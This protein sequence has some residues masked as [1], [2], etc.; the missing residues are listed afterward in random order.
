LE[1]KQKDDQKMRCAD[2]IRMDLRLVTSWTSSIVRYFFLFILL[3]KRQTLDKA[4]ETNDL[5]F[6]KSKSEP[7]RILL[8]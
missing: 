1:H 6:D 5:K 7:Y 4:H 2:G 3:L 8:G